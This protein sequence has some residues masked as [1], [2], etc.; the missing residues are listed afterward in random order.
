[1]QEK[2]ME[3]LKK[4]K[5][6]SIVLTTAKEALLK[7]VDK[8]QVY[9]DY[10]ESVVRERSEEYK[11]VM[12]LMDRCQGLLASKESLKSRHQTLIVDIDSEY[13]ELETFKEKKM[14]QTLDYNVKLSDLQQKCA[15]LAAHTLERIAYVKNIEERSTEKKLLIST[16]KLGILNMHLYVL[17]NETLDL[18]KKSSKNF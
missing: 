1:M 16:I 13:R 5:E 11:D 15:R 14:G 8:K 17:R 2:A 18:E 10:L 6:L 7:A 3:K 4:K 12:K 9:S